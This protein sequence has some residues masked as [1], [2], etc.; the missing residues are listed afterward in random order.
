MLCF[1][2]PQSMNKTYIIEANS[3]GSFKSGLDSYVSKSR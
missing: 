3:L 1:S 2:K